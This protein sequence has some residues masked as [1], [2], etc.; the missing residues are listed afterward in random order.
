MTYSCDHGMDS[1]FKKKKEMVCNQCEKGNF[2]KCE[3]THEGPYARWVCIYRTWRDKKEKVP[4]LRVTEPSMEFASALRRPKKN[5]W[6]LFTIG[7]E[8]KKYYSWL[9][10]PLD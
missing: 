5:G 4:A 7:K 1:C 9:G 6:T 8:P 3:F 10:T 2:E